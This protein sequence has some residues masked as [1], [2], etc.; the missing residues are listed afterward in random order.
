ML[1]ILNKENSLDAEYYEH[2]GYIYQKL[3]K[4]REAVKMW[5][6]AIETDNRKGE[7]INMIEKCR[8]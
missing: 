5:E 1:E 6:K 7:L 3:G 2:T 8:K 4:C